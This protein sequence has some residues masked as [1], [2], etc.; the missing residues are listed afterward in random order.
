VTVATADSDAGPPTV[1]S[2]LPAIEDRLA[3]ADGLVV[4][5]DFDGT[6]API[7]ADPGDAAVPAA[8][9]ATVERLS[10]HPRVAAAVVTG[11]EVAD[12]RDRLDLPGLGYA[13]NHGLRIVHDGEEIVHP[14][15][16][17]SADAIDE[18]AGTVADRLADREGAFVEHKGLTATVHY[19]Q[20]P[21]GVEP[22]VRETVDD[23]LADAGR[24]DEVAVDDGKQIFELRPPVDWDKGRAVEWLRERLTP[25]GGRWLAVYVGDDTTDEDA[26]RAVADDDLSVAVGREAVETA[27]RYR[28]G[29]P[30][31]VR[32]LLSWLARSGLDRLAG[33]KSVVE[34]G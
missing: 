27:A 8:T 11:R 4:L 25:D 31:D 6:L 10:A 34:V 30:E 33:G 24:A 21:D 18:V 26:F 20:A 15:A 22:A 7:V 13:G 32:T 23:A 29:D 16:R 14:E 17:A 3:R 5:L 9:R 2:D 28:V 19:R 1:W 12:V